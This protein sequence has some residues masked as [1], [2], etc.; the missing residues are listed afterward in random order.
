MGFK[1]SRNWIN[2][3]QIDE[4]LHC[5]YYIEDMIVIYQN[6]YIKK[7]YK[8]FKGKKKLKE[9]VGEKKIIQVSA[10]PI[11]VEV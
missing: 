6:D 5:S 4:T 7:N 10:C 8:Q 2:S 9:K 1:L 3:Y 11:G